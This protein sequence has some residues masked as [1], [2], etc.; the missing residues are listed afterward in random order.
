MH[1]PEARST[2]RADGFR[3]TVPGRRAMQDRA[4]A[5]LRLRRL[6]GSSLLALAVSAPG[7]ACTDDGPLFDQEMTQLR[8]FMRPA[9][10][11]ADPSNKYADDP[12]AAA[13]GKKL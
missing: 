4:L 6:V 1:R 5:S 8:E 13:L 9:G 10:P 12:A 11:P 3:A 7:L 2:R